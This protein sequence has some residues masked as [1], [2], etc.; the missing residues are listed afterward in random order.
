MKRQDLLNEL[1]GEFSEVGQPVLQRTE[2]S[3]KIYTVRVFEKNGDSIEEKSAGLVI[4]DEGQPSEEAYWLP[5][6][7]EKGSNQ[8]L[9]DVRAYITAKINDGTIDAGFLESVDVENQKATVWVIVPAAAQKHE[10]KAL[11][12]RNAQGSITHR[13]IDLVT[14]TGS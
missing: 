8:F 13:L 14:K 12:F 7:V 1:Q 9:A 6:P 11:L 4:K 3:L 5:R 10:K 2:G